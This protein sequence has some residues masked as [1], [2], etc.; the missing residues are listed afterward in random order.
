MQYIAHLR[1]TYLALHFNNQMNMEL[2]NFRFCRE[3][4]NSGQ[5]ANQF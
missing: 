5:E 2:I 3:T 1:G 4:K